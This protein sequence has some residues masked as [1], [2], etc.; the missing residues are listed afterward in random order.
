MNAFLALFLSL[1]FANTIAQLTSGPCSTLLAGSC[2][3]SANIGLTNNIPGGFSGLNAGFT[4]YSEMGSFGGAA[5]FPPI[6]NGYSL[7]GG[8]GIGSGFGSNG[9]GN[10]LGG[11]VGNTLDSSVGGAFGNS[12]GNTLGGGFSNGNGLGY[13]WGSGIAPGA[14]NADYN[15]NLAT[16]SLGGLGAIGNGAGFGTTG[17]GLGLINP[18]SD[19]D[20]SFVLN[21]PSLTGT[22]FTTPV[23]NSGSSS[24]AGP[25]PT[26]AAPP[27]TTAIP[28]SITTVSNMGMATTIGVTG[29]TVTALKVKDANGNIVHVT[30]YDP[31]KTSQLVQDR[32]LI[33]NLKLWN[34]YGS[35]NPSTDVRDTITFDQSLNENEYLRSQN[36][37][38]YA[39]MQADGNFVV[40]VSRVLIGK[41]A[42]W[43]TNTA[44]KG[45]SGT[46][47]MTLQ[48]RGNL[49]L[50]HSSNPSEWCSSSAGGVTPHRL[51]MQNDG[52]LV[53]YD[54]NNSPRWASGT[55]R[56]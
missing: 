53:L 23:L 20:A 28:T 18:I 29:G 27:V 40:Y 39:V 51:V 38:Y 5:S 17:L 12:F 47:K 16:T 15:G 35:C 19:S 7:G 30:N 50:S 1:L 10:T 41:N 22:T 3:P 55:K 2:I 6:G 33:D 48:N 26:A 36:K 14:S 37:A 9:I 13:N 31:A 43:S 42:L 45:A 54:K 49:V 21:T 56:D 46:R 32:Y 8:V 34:C 44:G 52:N 4:G 25:I 24:T 11:G